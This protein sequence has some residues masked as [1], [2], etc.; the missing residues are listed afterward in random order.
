MSAVMQSDEL[1]AAFD[2]ETRYNIYTII[3]KGLRGFMTDVL[4]RWGRMD[5]TDDCER[6]EATA[7]VR[8]LLAMCRSHLQH[9][10]DFIHPAIEKVRPGTTARIAHEHVEHVNEI[11]HLD[12]WLS[13]LQ[14]APA[15][16]R[17]ALARRIYRELTLFVA[18]N[19]EHM[20][21]EETDH[22][23]ALVAAYTDAEVLA[24]EHAIV[25]SLSPEE[26]FGGLRWMIPQIN[27]SERA[28]LLGGMKLGAPPEVFKLVM[29]LAREALSQR[30]YYK[31]EKALS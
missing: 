17:A 26:S 3:H 21:V 31:L 15:D 19:F 20:V 25:T 27:A 12:N 28:F 24:I 4:H 7:Q 8:A 18:D 6:A 13:T 22:H 1:A 10:N 29:E 16:M 30:D 9:E 5:V 11:D 2:A 23:R 14:A